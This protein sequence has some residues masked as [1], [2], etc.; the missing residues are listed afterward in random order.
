MRDIAV[1]PTVP[2]ARAVVAR[3]LWIYTN[4]DC[5]LACSYC[6]ASSSPRAPRRELPQPTFRRLIDEAAAAGLDEFFLTGGEPFRLP[7]AIERIAYAA[8]RG[9]TTVLTNGMLLRGRRMEAL[10]ALRELPLTLQVSLDA[11]IPELHDAYRGAG[12]WKATVASI[13]RLV[14]AGFRVTIGA[15]ETPR[16]A[17]AIGALE[18]FV[19]ELGASGFFLRPL[20]RRG[21][22]A[23]GVE[24]RAQ[25]VAPELTATLDGLY[26][27][28]QGAGE[29]MLL[30]RD[31]F[32]LASGLALMQ[33]NLDAIVAGGP[34]PQ[35][36]WCG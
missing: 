21:F 23:E 31:L 11:H 24:V 7:D 19:R 12:S 34:I 27:H 29:A 25:D 22:S 8:E 36:Y 13:R 35:R 5:N 3:R 28:P 16:N 2:D 33:T 20:T 14:D 6:L 32:P 30:S 4:F 17:A 1:A 26:W 9:A 18:A 10:H 15:T